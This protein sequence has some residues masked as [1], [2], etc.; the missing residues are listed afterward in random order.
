MTNYSFDITSYH[1]KINKKKS[2]PFLVLILMIIS[3]SV[4]WYFINPKAE[5]FYQ[6]YIVYAD[7]FN[8]YKQASS[9]AS[10][11]QTEGGAGYIFY[12]QYY[13]VFVNT[14][15][16]ENSAEK[17]VENIKDD[18][19]NANIYHLK[20]N[21]LNSFKN[22]KLDQQK[23]LYDYNTSLANTLLEL[24]GNSIKYDSHE[25]SYE[26]YIISIKNSKE[27]TQK[28]STEC[29]KHLSYD[30]TFNTIKSN[31]QKI[32]NSLDAMSS[33]DSVN[34]TWKAKFYN[35]QI[36]ESYLSIASSF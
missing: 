16:N 29:I 26:Q 27:Y 8:T 25:T 10:K 11:I 24:T 28:L 1:K 33:L 35:C 20:I 2:I 7:R 12:D 17:V 34:I 36:L 15:A 18:Y 5:N 19:S 31:I 3:L 6:F 13:Y 9:L 21:K 4:C 22:S 23:S 30:L 14:Y 32:N